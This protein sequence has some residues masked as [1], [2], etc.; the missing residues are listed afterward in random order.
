MFEISSLKYNEKSIKFYTPNSMTKR[1][2]ANIFQKE[3]ITIEWMN[4]IQ[5]NEVVLDVGANVG[6]YTLMSGVSRLARV[7]AFEPEASNY[8]LLNE[9]IKLN[10][11]GETV[12][13]WNCGVLDYDGQSV[14]YMSD[15]SGFGR[16]IHSVDEELN[17]DLTPKETKFKQ[18]I[19]VITLDSFC[20]NLEIVPDHIKIDVDGLEHRIVSGNLATLEKAKTVIIEIQTT[21]KEHL[22]AVDMILSLGFNLDKDQVKSSMR[23]A[24]DFKGAAEHLFYK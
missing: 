5:P 6:M 9:N 11:I 14:L 13:A 10:N 4:N 16:A 7:F 23:S 18:G 12:T 8:F 21:L 19:N 1:R 20:K 24:G 2:V 3:P 17:F 15:L 22:A